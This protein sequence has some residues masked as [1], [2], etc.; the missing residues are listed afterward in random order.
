MFKEIHKVRKEVK[1]TAD[2]R[3]IKKLNSK[4]FKSKWLL[5]EE[6]TVISTRSVEETSMRIQS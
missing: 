5:W 2:W 6:W 3:P 1:K 4:V